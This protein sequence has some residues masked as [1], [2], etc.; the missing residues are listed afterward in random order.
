MGR[1]QS[2]VKSMYLN[3][4]GGNMPY[5]RAMGNVHSGKHGVTS[6][7]YQDGDMNHAVR[8]DSVS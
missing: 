1:L 5:N 3:M 6:N 4:N 2:Q 7:P 8:V